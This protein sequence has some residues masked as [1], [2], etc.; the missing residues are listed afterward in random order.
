MQFQ[1]STY[2]PKLI[3][4][5]RFGVDVDREAMVSWRFDYSHQIST[6]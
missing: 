4:G 6:G 1:A 3:L 5:R 2:A